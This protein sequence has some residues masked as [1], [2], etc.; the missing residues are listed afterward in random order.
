MHVREKPPL[1]QTIHIETP[2]GRTYRWAEDERDPA[3][4]PSNVRHSDTDPGG[5]E[6]AGATLPRTPGIDYA[7]LERLSTVQF[8]GAGGEIDGEYRLER[9]PQTSGDQMSISPDLVGWQA[10]LDDNKSVRELIIDRELARFQGITAQ[11]RINLTSVWNP[12]NDGQV[13]SDDPLGDP[14]LKLEVSGHMPGTSG[15]ICESVYDPG[16]GLKVGAFQFAATEVR[17][18]AGS[19]W[20]FVAGVGP[21]ATSLLSETVMPDQDANPV[22]FTRWSATNPDRI[23]RVQV[24][25]GAAYTADENERWR[26]LKHLAVI[27]NHGLPL[28]QIGPGEDGF[29]ASDVLAYAVPKWAPLLTVKSDS[30]K[31]SSFVIP[32][33]PFLDLTTVGEIT[34]QVS[35]FELPSWGVW[36]HKEFRWDPARTPRKRWRARAAESKLEATG[37][38][39]DRLWESIMVQYADVDG[40]TRTV[41]PPGS[42]A[43]VEDARLRDADPENPAN[44]LG[45]VRRDVLVIGT[46]TPNSAI[47]VGVRFLQ[48]TKLL[49]TSGR[50]TLPPYVLDDRGVLHPSSRVRSAD[51]IAFIDARD[52]SY[53]WIVRADKTRDS[54]ACT[55]DLDSPPEGLQALLERLGA[56]LLHLGIG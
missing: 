6:S 7:D 14:A 4:V 17:G 55:V 54:P 5:F 28:R 48:Q 41:G 45:I 42:G 19:T 13:V 30:I 25:Y 10:H 49:D 35:R 29:L 24:F 50:A 51:A 36:E 9:A 8:L 53:R 18:M 40:T 32:H 16:S 15:G 44:K 12:Q 27:G 46:A 47:Q 37:P 26:L 34:R 38:Q 2:S 3:N 33:A 20:S 22:A 1:R 11:R 52:T 21:D 31:Q 56:A 39:V 23:L 43:D